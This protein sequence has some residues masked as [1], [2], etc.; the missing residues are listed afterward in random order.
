MYELGWPLVLFGSVWLFLIPDL[1]ADWAFETGITK[2]LNLVGASS[3][4]KASP[5]QIFL[6]LIF[7]LLTYLVGLASV[8][9]GIWKWIR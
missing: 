7:A 6:P 4:E 1:T 2:L 8:I 5:A 3:D 9:V